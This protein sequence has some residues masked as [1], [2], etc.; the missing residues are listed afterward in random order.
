ML[1]D[2]CLLIEFHMQKSEPL[3]EA[4]LIV[5]DFVFKNR[6]NQTDLIYELSEPLI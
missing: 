2:Y 3:I 5:C 4:D 6:C 1:P